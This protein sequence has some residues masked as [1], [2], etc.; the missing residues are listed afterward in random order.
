MEKISSTIRDSSN[1]FGNGTLADL[2]TI[3]LVFQKWEQGKVFVEV[4]AHSSIPLP[5]V[6][7]IYAECPKKCDGFSKDIFDSLNNRNVAQIRF[8]ILFLSKFLS[9]PLSIPTYK[10]SKMI[11][12]MTALLNSNYVH[13]YP[14]KLVEAVPELETLF[15]WHRDAIEQITRESAATVSD[16][17]RIANLDD[18]WKSLV[19]Q[20]F[21]TNVEAE[22]RTTRKRAVEPETDPTKQCIVCQDQTKTFAAV[23]CGHK[24]LCEQDAD[25]IMKTTKRCPICRS[26]MTMCIRVFE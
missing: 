26:Q 21:L 7:L 19:F 15:E 24:C 25:Q 1:R 17:K 3:S 10:P 11:E 2:M 5:P 20:T 16:I 22:G 13:E 12:N 9:D 14:W 6:V 8:S 18:S 4:K 23:P